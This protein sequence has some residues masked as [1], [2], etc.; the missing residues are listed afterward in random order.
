MFVHGI[1][2]GSYTWDSYLS[3]ESEKHLTY[4]GTAV[5]EDPYNTFTPGGMRT[6]LLDIHIEGGS[7][8]QGDFYF[9]NF[10]NNKDISFSAQGFQVKEAVIKI[11]QLTGS[12][13]V[14]LVAHSMGGLASRAY[15]QLFNDDNVKGLITIG[16]PHFGSPLAVLDGLDGTLL[17]QIP[18]LK[19][20]LDSNVKEQLSPGSFDLDI[21]SL[22]ENPLPNNLNYYAIIVRGGDKFPFENLYSDKQGD[23]VVSINSQSIEGWESSEIVIDEESNFQVEVHTKETS[24]DDIRNR[25]WNVLMSWQ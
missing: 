11:I 17:T 14:Y 7:A 13:G 25:I 8:D 10:S 23:G 16:T 4:G 20:I 2:S 22:D 18:T 19:C 5:V 15:L 9:M 3:W 6:K 1:C 21:L 12:D 24:N